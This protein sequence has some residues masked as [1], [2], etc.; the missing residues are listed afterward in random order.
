MLKRSYAPA[1]GLSSSG[2]TLPLSEAL[3]LYFVVFVMRS[4]NVW[5]RKHA[6]SWILDSRP[7]AWTPVPRLVGDSHASAGRRRRGIALA[8]ALGMGTIM[9]VRTIQCIVAVTVIAAATGVTL[10]SPARASC[11]ATALRKQALLADCMAGCARRARCSREGRAFDRA[12][13]EE[14]CQSNYAA[15]VRGMPCDPNVRC[16]PLPIIPVGLDAQGRDPVPP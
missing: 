3:R 1:T 11:V 4:P 15:A 13:C 8:L 12:P 5:I 7:L 6:A 9:L 10:T 14:R 2:E 16:V